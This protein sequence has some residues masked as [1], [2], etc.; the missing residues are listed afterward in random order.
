[1]KKF[2]ILLF[3][4]L[5]QL[6]IYAA[7]QKDDS[8][9]AVSEISDIL[10]KDADAVVRYSEDYIEIQELG[11]V[12]HK[13]KKVIT[14]LKKSGEEHAGLT[15]YYDKFSKIKAISGNVYDKNGELVRKI[16]NKEIHDFSRF[17]GF[18]LYTDNRV[19]HIGKPGLTPPYTVEYKYEEEVKG[20]LSLPKWLPA[21]SFDISIE[22]AVLKV[23]DKTRNGFRFLEKNFSGKTDT[24][25]IIMTWEI[26]NFPVIKKEPLN[27]DITQY[28][29]IVFLAPNNFKLSGYDGN[30]SN[31][32]NFG[33]RK[34]SKI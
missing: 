18:S 33:K 24:S 5:S 30:A 12:I 27:S 13:V 25:A 23:H 15:V 3:L 31:W 10:K 20:I 34:E 8:K 14:I 19:K 2:Y 32:Q 1:M 16:K 29:P 22:K 6:S 28:L 4:L 7:I 26:S 17:D 9:Y 21:P 11:K